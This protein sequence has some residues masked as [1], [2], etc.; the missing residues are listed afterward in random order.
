M[1]CIATGIL[2]FFCCRYSQRDS[3]N[4]SNN[5]FSEYIYS[6]KNL[7]DSLTCS[8]SNLNVN[9]INYSQS[10]ILDNLKMALRN[11]GYS[12]RAAEDISTAYMTLSNYGHIPPLTSLS[13]GSNMINI[14]NPSTFCSSGLLSPNNTHN[15]SISSPAPY[16]GSSLCRDG[17]GGEYGPVGSSNDLLSPTSGTSDNDFYS[18]RDRLS[19]GSSTTGAYPGNSGGPLKGLD[20]PSYIGLNN[21]SFGLGV[22]LYG[23][24]DK[25][26]LPSKQDMEVP[27]T[28]V[29]AILGPKGK[30]IVE[31][32]QLTNATIQISKKG[33]YAPGTRNRLVHITG[34]PLSVAKAQFLIQHRLQQE[35]IKRNQQA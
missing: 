24:S 21:N 16:I 19:F 29:G 17:S 12:D 20:D 34:T 33:V 6:D 25:H 3:S 2:N 32:Q 4:D 31:I 9:R 18:L 7:T 5:N 35:E 26:S 28:I 1:K 8:M 15:S 10:P 13:Y 14:N 23:P 27:E 30:G 22:G 11:S